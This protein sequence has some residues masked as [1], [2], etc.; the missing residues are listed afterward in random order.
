MSLKRLCDFVPGLVA[1]NRAPVSGDE[2]ARAGAE[3][4]ITEQTGAL[5]HAEQLRQ[6]VWP[7]LGEVVLVTQTR[8]ELAG[9]LHRAAV[10]QQVG[11]EED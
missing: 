8:E 10:A 4:Q 9:R 11:A 5:D 2:V 6:Q 1:S 7:L 3:S